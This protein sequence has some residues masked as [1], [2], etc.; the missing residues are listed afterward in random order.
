M[1]V[2]SNTKLTLENPIKRHDRSTFD[3]HM[4]TPNTPSSMFKIWIDADAAPRD[5][6]EL[7]FKTSAR[8]KIPVTLVANQTMAVPRSSLIAVVTVVDGANVAD[9]YIVQHANAG[10]IAITADVPLAAE[11]TAKQVF[12]I[13]PRGHVYDANNVASRLATRDLMDAARGAGFELSGPSPYS[14]KDRNRF[15]SSLDRLVTKANKLMATKLS[16]NASK[17]I[18]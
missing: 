6:K 9:K 1:I 16:S 3:M 15:A 4:E 18:E 2:G 13:D 5:V 7:I 17:P 14:P 8:L 11:L 10:D 12:V